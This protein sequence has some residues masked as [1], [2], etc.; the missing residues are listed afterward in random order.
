MDN[1]YEMVV[2]ENDD[3]EW[4]SDSVVLWLGGEKIEKWLSG[5]KSG[6]S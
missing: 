1:E 3:S 4:S 5:G 2:K 6:Q